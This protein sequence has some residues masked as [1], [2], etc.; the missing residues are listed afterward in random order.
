MQAAIVDQ[1]PMARL[2]RLQNL[3]MRQVDAR[4]IAGLGIVVQ[5][6]GL[7]DRQRF[8][9]AEELADPQLGPLQVRQDA[10]RPPDGGL[11]RADALDQGAHGIVV[12]MAHIDAEDIRAGLE[13]AADHRLLGRSRTERGEDLDLAAASHGVL[14]PVA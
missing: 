3:R 13:E 2:D 11:Y 4:G 12:G 5:R 1:Q 6:E 14:V 10:D 7:P 9:A 8:A